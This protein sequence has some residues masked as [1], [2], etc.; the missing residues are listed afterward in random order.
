MHSGTRWGVR[1]RC[2]FTLSTPSLS[3]PSSPLTLLPLR[4]QRKQRQM[5]VLGEFSA[6]FSHFFEILTFSLSPGQ[7]V[8]VK[9]RKKPLAM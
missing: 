7:Q 6:K 5:E 2:A 3:P 1:L 9:S 4:M 8:A